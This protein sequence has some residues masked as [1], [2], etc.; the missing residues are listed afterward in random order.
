MNQNAETRRVAFVM[1][2]EG[3]EQIELTE[4]WSAV[5][6]AGYEP[7]LVAPDAGEVHAFHHLDRADTFP[8]DAIARDVYAADFAMAVLPGGVANPDQLRVDGDAVSL[9]QS[10]VDA[11]KPIAVICHGPWSL[12][13]ADVLRGRSITSAPN[14]RTD[15]ENAGGVWHDR[16][17]VVCTEGPNIMI[18]SRKPD[19]LPAF[20]E[21]IVAHL[22]AAPHRTPTL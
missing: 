6:N 7:V 12:V 21:Q 4:P 15:I 19:D 20:C 5:K 16:E 18:S 3:V 13:E 14:I 11:G 9:F 10:F 8:V 2:N 22:D 17:V 1:A